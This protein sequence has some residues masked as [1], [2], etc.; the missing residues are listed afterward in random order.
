MSAAFDSAIRIHPQPTMQLT[1][2]ASDCVNNLWHETDWCTLLW[3]VL[4]SVSIQ[5]WTNH[6]TVA[7]FK[8]KKLP[9][10]SF[11]TGC[12]GLKTHICSI[13]GQCSV[14]LLSN[15][16]P[17]HLRRTAVI[18]GIGVVCGAAMLAEKGSLQTERER[19]WGYFKHVSTGQRCVWTLRLKTDKC[20]SFLLL[21]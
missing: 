8:K 20:V 6:Y 10:T 19:N 16:L 12:A 17:V 4:M 2:L 9:G 1:S 13:L 3:L 18:L 15:L 5:T 21:W 14:G 11:P 7:T